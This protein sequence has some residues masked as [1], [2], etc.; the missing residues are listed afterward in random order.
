MRDAVDLLV[1]HTGSDN[2]PDSETDDQMNACE[3]EKREKK[4]KELLFSLLLPPYSW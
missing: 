1:A 3:C 4:E 2:G